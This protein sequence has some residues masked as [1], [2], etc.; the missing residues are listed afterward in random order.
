MPVDQ[1]L[2]H[3][4]LF[5]ASPST[6]GNPH[7]LQTTAR[8]VANLMHRAGLDVKIERTTGAPVVL[9]WRMGRHPFTLLLYHHYDAAPPGPWHNWQHEPFQLAERE[10]KI[11]GR[12]VAHGKGPLVAHLQALRALLEAEH[13]L[14]HGVIVVVEGEYLSGS[15]HLEEVIR[16]YA[17]TGE[18]HACLGSGG[19]RDAEG[20]PFCYHGSK[21]LL[22]VRLT[23]KGATVPLPSGLSASVTNPLWRLVWAVSEVKGADEDIRIGGFYDLVDGPGRTERSLLRQVRI[24]EAERLAAWGIPG[25]L[26]DLSG[27]ALVRTE[28]TLPT[29]NLTA[30]HI[31]PPAALANACIPTAASARLDFHLVPRQEPEEVFDL[32]CKHLEARLFQDIGVE[33]VS[34]AYAPVQ[35]RGDD[36]FIQQLAAAGTPLFGAPLRVLPFAPFP[37]PLP[38][39]A[40]SLDAPVAS[41]AVARH[42][43]QEYGPNEHISPDDLVNHGR[44]LLELM[45]STSAYLPAAVRH[46]EHA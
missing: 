5:C 20:R 14:P 2:N 15:P 21:G 42:D 12:G 29:C 11:Y 32:L 38:F 36:P 45:T 46:K 28:V 44:L 18:V 43:S 19:E 41:V 25:F 4:R 37:H 30:L 8:L 35:S 1:L 39:L 16:R 22:Q 24:N 26:F 7:Q 9:G 40:R 33:K 13:E 23:A 31:D 27:A 6:S 34:G 17:S 10:G 3:L